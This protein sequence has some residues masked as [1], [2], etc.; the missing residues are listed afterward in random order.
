[1]HTLA[2]QLMVTSY[3][4]A[5]LV[6]RTLAAKD[7]TRPMS[8]LSPGFEADAEA[9]QGELGGFVSLDELEK[10]SFVSVSASFQHLDSGIHEEVGDH[11]SG[12]ED[13]RSWASEF[14][15][16]PDESNFPGPEA[17]V[18]PQSKAIL[19]PPPQPR[20]QSQGDAEGSLPYRAAEEYPSVGVQCSRPNIHR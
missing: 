15:L 11:L 1:M 12:A 6:K 16:P 20:I 9:M 13:P 4:I 14:D 7:H 3:D 10:S 17:V 19:A 18:A 2:N 5:I 8:A